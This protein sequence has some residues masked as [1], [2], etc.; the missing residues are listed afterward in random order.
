MD[1]LVGYY[2]YCKTFRIETNILDGKSVIAASYD[3]QRLFRKYLQTSFDR[4][5]K[6]IQIH[7]HV[8]RQYIDEITR[9]FFFS[10]L[11]TTVLYHEQSACK[12]GSAASL[13]A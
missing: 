11:S 4:I 13:A 5:L 3:F 7:I 6:L 1:I 2:R 8:V 12:P 9:L 10:S